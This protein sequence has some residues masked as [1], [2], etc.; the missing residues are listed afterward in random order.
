[1]TWSEI[2][3]LSLDSIVVTTAVLIFS[4][5]SRQELREW[6][7]YILPIVGTVLVAMTILVFL[8]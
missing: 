7:L 3:L 5:S 2:V 4:T 1:M 6:T 8:G